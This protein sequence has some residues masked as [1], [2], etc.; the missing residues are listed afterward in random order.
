MADIALEQPINTETDIDQESCF[1]AN[2]ELEEKV[3]NKDQGKK[4]S[5]FLEG[6][7]DWFTGL[8]SSDEKVEEEFIDD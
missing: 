2:T 5:F 8:F 4:K 3:E 1:V 6:I 7:V